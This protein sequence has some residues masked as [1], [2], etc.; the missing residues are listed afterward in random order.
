[1]AGLIRILVLAW[2]LGISAPSFAQSPREAEE[3]LEAWDMPAA[4]KMI[5]AL[6]AASP[7]SIEV[8]YLRAR[9]DFMEGR[10]EQSIQRID[11]A[12]AQSPLAELQHFRELV[13]ATHNVTKN[14]KKVRSPKGYFEIA[15]EP[16]KDEVLLPFAF[17]A[18]DKAYEELGRD[19]GHFPPVPVRVE[20][21][22]RTSTLAEVST[23]TDAEIRT[24]GTIALCKYNRLMITSPKA[25]MRGYGWVDTVVHEYVHYVV[26]Q[27]TGSRV[28]IWMH[29]GLA[30]FLERRW[31]GPD[32]FRLPPSSEKLLQERVAK[33]DF[34][35]FEQMHPSMAKLPSQED[36]AMAFAEV[37]TAME[38]LRERVGADAFRQML[39]EIVGGVEAQ[40]AFAKVLGMPFSQFEREWRE[41]LKT[42]KPSSYPEDT[43]F[44][45]RLVFKDTAPTTELGSMPQPK[46]R[47]H[48][49]LGEMMQAR[50]RWD[51]AIVQ[52]RKA[53]QIAGQ[54]NPVLQT[55]LAQSF[56]ALGKAEDAYE[57]LAP[58][59]QNFPGY[60]TTW[61][62]LGKA[63][64]ALG[65]WPEAR[66]FLIEAARINPFDPE[67]HS[68][69][70][71]VYRQLGMNDK[72]EE[73]A[74]F[75]ALVKA[76]P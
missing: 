68:E 59:V 1:M 6:E 13:S 36:A 66:E 42:R 37:Y 63:A 48:M 55:R 50:E 14:Y 3:L 65:K 43:G 71:R 58:T 22:P 53:E 18:L 46:A 32:E 61:I 47:D 2:V 28:P 10:Y 40:R 30:K 24:S 19:L 57:S 73:S 34:I 35:S 21:Y 11:Q 27:K 4:S 38:F 17:E 60:V 15:V 39:D 74:R 45:D 41:S 69:L 26:N 67:V 72:A 16:G 12:L 5:E 54:G 31:R 49:H 8:L 23:L 52:Y 33:K 56:L 29:E 76:G 75:E 62:M 9:L 20:V 7:E 51:A 64:A 70:A 25:L 44:E